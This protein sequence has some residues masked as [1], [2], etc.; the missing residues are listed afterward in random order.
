MRVRCNCVAVV[1][2]GALL[3]SLPGCG[4][5]HFSRTTSVVTV[6]A[7]APSAPDPFVSKDYEVTV[8]S[9]SNSACRAGV[10][11]LRNEDAPR[12][13]ENLQRAVDQNPKD[14]DAHFALG[15][16]YEMN[17]QYEKALEEFKAA[18][19]LTSKTNPEYDA[20]RRRAQAKLEYSHG[21]QGAARP[22]SPGR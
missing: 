17:G 10:A 13:I 12:A 9:S 16:A 4:R 22:S 20:S 1:F 3:A 11:D 5:L 7:A 15:I 21:G 8:K 19:R 18:N 6:H 14:E 2:A